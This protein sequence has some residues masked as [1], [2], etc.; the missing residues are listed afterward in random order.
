[1][2][3]CIGRWYFPISGKA[4]ATYQ[5][6]FLIA[7]PF[8]QGE[9]PVSFKRD[10]VIIGQTNL[11]RVNQGDGLYN[12]ALVDDPDAAAEAVD[13]FLDDWEAEES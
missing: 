11:P 1:V 2:G 8:G 10:G 13:V 5:S 3:A 12:I 4:G 7:D 6:E 9:V